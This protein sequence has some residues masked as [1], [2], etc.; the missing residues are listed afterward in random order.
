MARLNIAGFETGDLTEFLSTSGT[1]SVNAVTKRTGG[2]S[3]RSNPTTTAVGWGRLATVAASGAATPFNLAT[4]WHRFYFLC[5]TAP[6]PGLPEDPPPSEEICE[7]RDTAAAVKFCVRIDSNRHLV[8]YAADGTTLLAQGT[9]VLALDTW[10]RIEINCATGNPAAYEVLING[11]SELSGT[12]NVGTANNGYIYLGKVTDRNGQTVD[13]YYDDWTADDAAYPGAGQIEVMQPDGNS[14]VYTGWTASAGDKYACV[15]EIPHNSDTDYIGSSTNAAAY[16]ATLE[17][18]A[19]AGISGTINC[20]KS[21]GVQRK[22]GV[23]TNSVKV[24]LRSSTTD[25]DTSGVSSTAYVFCAKVFA[26]NPADSQAWET[27]DLDGIEVG[28]V[29]GAAY[30]ARCTMVCAMVDFRPPTNY[31][32]S[33]SAGVGAAAAVGRIRSVTRSAQAAVGTLAFAGRLRGVIRGAEAAVGAVASAERVRA[34]ARSASAAIGLMAGV[35]VVLHRA[36]GRVGNII[37]RAFGLE[38]K[39]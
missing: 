12:G 33:A 20:V 23:Q 21:I 25:S 30:A 28:V 26:V 22:T 16:T 14:A 15:D 34:V 18:A 35:G 8:A 19:N 27:T 36:T 38:I 37:N 29:N 31:S 10:Y 17:S 6:L 1:C 9:T 11:V 4:I 2:Y 39:P 3:F 24:R 32:L 5:H 13:F 7:I